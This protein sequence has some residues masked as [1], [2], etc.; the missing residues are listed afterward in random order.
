MLIVTLDLIAVSG[1]PQL[2]RFETFWGE[3][4]LGFPLQTPRTARQGGCGWC[5][6]VSGVRM[7]A[8]ELGRV[9]AVPD[10]EMAQQ[11]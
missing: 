1:G 10:Q 9:P 5:S 4:C 3:L 8:K 2:P 6:P 11:V 7:L